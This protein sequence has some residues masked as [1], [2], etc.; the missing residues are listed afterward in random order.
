M[1]L[2]MTAIGLMTVFLAGSSAAGTKGSTLLTATLTGGETEVPDGGDPNGTGNASIRLNPE[3]G[4]VCFA[5]DWERIR[6]PFMAHIHRGA[7]GVA[8]PI[9]VVLF[10]SEQPLPGTIRG[11]TGCA[12][13]VSADL[14][15][16]I[17]ANPS[18]FYVNVHNTPF[19]GG[20][21]RGQLQQTSPV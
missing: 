3:T 1:L 7:E 21:I 11:V 13:D 20:A 17:I 16:R 4:R 9:R 5:L 14:I 18:G 10:E 2:V 8:G 19:P 15:N 12:R 6:S